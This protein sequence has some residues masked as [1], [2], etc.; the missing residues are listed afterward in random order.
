MVNTRTC[1]FSLRAA[2]R[3]PAG[4]QLQ[5]PASRTPASGRQF[6]AA[7]ATG[8]ATWLHGMIDVLKYVAGGATEIQLLWWPK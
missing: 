2:M 5:F 4:A 8:A 3:R 6:D 1:T 7:A